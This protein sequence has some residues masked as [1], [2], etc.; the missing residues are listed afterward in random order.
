MSST[1][2]N[3]DKI[4]F[5]NVSGGGGGLPMF[6]CAGYLHYVSKPELPEVVYH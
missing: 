3:S 4:S 1:S 5:I 6:E 2:S